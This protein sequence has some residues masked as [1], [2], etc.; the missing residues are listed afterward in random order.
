MRIAPIEEQLENY[1]ASLDAAYERI[2]KLTAIMEAA[3]Y[4]EKGMRGATGTKVDEAS[5]KAGRYNLR[6][7]IQDYRS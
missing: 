6:K 4:I 1:Q 7:T 3:D 2:D 5:W